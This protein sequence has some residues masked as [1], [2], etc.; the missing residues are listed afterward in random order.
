MT[1]PSRRPNGH[2][3]DPV[4]EALARHTEMTGSEILEK[5]FVVDGEIRATV[6]CMVGPNSGKFLEMVREWLRSEGFNE[7]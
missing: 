7:D 6:F 3:I 1:T 4:C 5:F 2:K